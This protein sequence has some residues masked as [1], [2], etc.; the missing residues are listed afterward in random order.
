MA[1]VRACGGI[2]N[3]KWRLEKSTP[4]RRKT[5]LGSGTGT[6]TVAGSYAPSR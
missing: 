6:P 4:S 5:V 2:G 3:H 1:T